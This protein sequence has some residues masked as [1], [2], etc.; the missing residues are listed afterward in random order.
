MSKLLLLYFGLKDKIEKPHG[1]CT[2]HV[3][4]V[5]NLSFLPRYYGN[6]FK[7]KYFYTSIILNH[8]LFS[9]EFRFLKFLK[10]L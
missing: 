8:R 4:F 1:P 10:L 3:I 6:H 2:I 7:P 9:G 5:I